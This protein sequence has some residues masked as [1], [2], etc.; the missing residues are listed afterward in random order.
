MIRVLLDVFVLGAGAF[1][2][3]TAPTPL[4]PSALD[5]EIAVDLLFALGAG[6]L[7]GRN[8]RVLKRL[9]IIEQ[10]KEKLGDSPPNISYM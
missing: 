7:V 8:S 5:A 9:S 1:G 10:G 2:P 3:S 6:A 4:S